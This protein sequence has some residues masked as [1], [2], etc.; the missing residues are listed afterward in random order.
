[1]T[2]EKVLNIKEIYAYLNHYPRS[3]MVQTPDL[4]EGFGELADRREHL[5]WVGQPEPLRPCFALE[6]RQLW[7]QCVSF[8]IPCEQDTVCAL[9]QSSEWVLRA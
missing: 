7:Q 5:R 3:P 6:F 9:S 8:A 2:F 1:V 4:T